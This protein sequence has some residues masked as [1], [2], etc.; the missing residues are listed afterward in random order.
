MTATQLI[1]L[2]TI[3]VVSR[4][5]FGAP[6]DNPP[7]PKHCE[8]LDGDCK[9]QQ[10]EKYCYSLVDKGAN[11]TKGGFC[12]GRG[13]CADKVYTYKYHGRIEDCEGAIETL[14]VHGFVVELDV[15]Y[16]ATIDWEAVNTFLTE[17]GGA[18]A[19]ECSHAVLEVIEA[20]YGVG[21]APDGSSAAACIVCLKENVEAFDWCDYTTCVQDETEAVNEV[22]LTDLT[23]GMSCE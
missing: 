6:C 2:C 19:T 11:S 12:E 22:K 4:A 8:Y 17:E 3:A 15:P 18:C 20:L 16:K 1:T 10:R 13:K 5:S 9:I 14:P 7:V 23:L 21:E